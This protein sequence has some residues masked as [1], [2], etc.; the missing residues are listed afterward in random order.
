MITKKT[1]AASCHW[2]I[3][4]CDNI[5]ISK[6]VIKFIMHLDSMTVSFDVYSLLIQQIGLKVCRR[7]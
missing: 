7:S 4:T 2:L 5:E 3:A 6:K 1:N